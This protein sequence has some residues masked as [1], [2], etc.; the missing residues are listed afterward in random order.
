ML[1]KYGYVAATEILSRRD[2]LIPTFAAM[3]MSSGTDG[4]ASGNSLPE[5]I[6]YGTYEL[7]ERDINR[8][9]SFE[10]LLN[11]RAK[12]VI[13]QREIK[14]R[15]CQILLKQF[16]DKGCKIVL[17]DLRNMY[18]IPCVRCYL[19]DSNLRIEHHGGTVVRSD[20]YSAVYAALHEA[21]MGYI[22]YFVGTRDDF[23]SLLNKDMHMGYKRGQEMFSVG[24]KF[25]KISYPP[26]RFNSIAEELECVINKLT[27][28]GVRH[29]VVVNTSPRD[30]YNVKSVKVII[31]RLEL[32]A[33]G[34]QYKPSSFFHEKL[35]RTV[36]LITDLKS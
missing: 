34:G 13:D 15:R 1:K 18:H 14:D 19:Y 6:L 12:L 8:I 9:Y 36:R 7:I 16:E 11:L 21:Y 17:L 29:I 3:S 31:P 35:N 33:F 30:K 28:V 24:Q 4:N 20:F 23:Q 25:L 22:I 2:I 32:Y 5:A 27:T 26:V 10:I